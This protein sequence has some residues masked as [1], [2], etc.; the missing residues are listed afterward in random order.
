MGKKKE[1]EIPDGAP[2][3]MMTFCDCMTLLLTF[4]VLLISFATF[5]KNTLPQL[6]E[7]FARALPAIG[8]V[9]K[10]KMES[11]H[12]KHQSNDQSHQPEGTET[13]T[14]S[15][16]QTSNYM[17][18]KKPLDFRNLKV[19]TVPSDKFFWGRGAAISEEGRRILDTL[20]VFLKAQADRVVISENGPDGNR[21]L[22]MA[23]AMAV[24]NYLAD[25]QQVDP[26]CLNISVSTTQR[27]APDARQLEITLLDRSVYE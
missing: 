2:E 24:L 18:E 7:S 11:I 16:S 21:T 17:R 19:F 25:Q 15:Q 9:S 10:E 5:E 13:R 20:A 6:G 3:W 12:K 14:L 27:L 26:A 4:F 8:L 23:R 22:G 1:E